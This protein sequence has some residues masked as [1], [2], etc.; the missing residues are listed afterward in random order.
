MIPILLGRRALEI[1]T[2]LTSS[3]RSVGSDQDSQSPSDQDTS[4]TTTVEGLTGTDEKTGSD[5]TSDGDHLQMTRLHLLLQHGRVLE[6]PLELF[7]VF[8]ASRDDLATETYQEGKSVGRS[9]HFRL[10]T[11]GARLDSPSVTGGGL[12]TLKVETRSG[13]ER[14]FRGVVDFRSVGSVVL[15]VDSRHDGG[16]GLVAILG[17]LLLLV[18]GCCARP[19]MDDGLRVGLEGDVDRGATSGT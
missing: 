19:R 15:L 17:I 5:G 10:D 11:R 8:G 18:H 1:S 13:P 12:V 9:A 7:G 6:S 4:G 14:L 16:V 3:S 2:A